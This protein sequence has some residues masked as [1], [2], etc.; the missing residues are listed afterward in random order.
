MTCD[1]RNEIVDTLR[2][3]C[4]IIKV[5]KGCKK[6]LDVCNP[7][8]TPVPGPVYIRLKAD[9]GFLLPDP[10]GAA[11]RDR[12][13]KWGRSEAKKQLHEQVS[14]LKAVDDIDTVCVVDEAHLLSFEMLEEIRFLLNVRFDSTSPVA[15]IAFEPTDYARYV[16][17][18]IWKEYFRPICH[19]R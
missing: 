1:I 14:I 12:Q 9:A 7:R 18:W 11:G 15:L 6:V 2:A 8:S 17:Q 3:V 5:P 13:I 16:F 10:A 4:C 19:L